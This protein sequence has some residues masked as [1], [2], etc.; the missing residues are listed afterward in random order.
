MTE[1]PRRQA[2]DEEEEAQIDAQVNEG[3]PTS[4]VERAAEPARRVL[5]VPKSDL[6]ASKPKQ[7]RS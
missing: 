3:G 5:Y 7:K 6:P 2:A 4:P 1:A